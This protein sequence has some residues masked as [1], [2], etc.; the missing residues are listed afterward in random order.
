[1]AKWKVKYDQAMNKATEKANAANVIEVDTSEVPAEP[2]N[3]EVLVRQVVSDLVTDKS[4][5]CEA[6]SK[7]L[8]RS[9][10]PGP[11]RLVSLR[12]QGDTVVGHSSQ[13]TYH[14]YTPAGGREEKVWGTDLVTIRFR[15]VQGNWLID[16]QE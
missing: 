1:M 5:F 10:Q 4:G 12:I 8:G 15:K 16:K 2:P 9:D 13:L 6:V 7:L 14:L 3:D 11:G